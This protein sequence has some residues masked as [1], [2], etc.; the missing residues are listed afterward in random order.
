VPSCAQQHQV[1]WRC[2]TYCGRSH[3]SQ[4]TRSAG[5][6]RVYNS[7][8]SSDG[9]RI[10]G[11]ASAA[12]FHHRNSVVHSAVQRGTGGTHRLPPHAQPNTTHSQHCRAAAASRSM[13]ST[14]VLTVHTY[15]TQRSHTPPLSLTAVT[16]ASS[17]A[18]KNA[19]TQRR[20]P[21]RDSPGAKG[22]WLSRHPGAAWTRGQPQAA[23]M[24]TNG[25]QPHALRHQARWRACRQRLL[26]P[27]RPHNSTT[28]RGELCRAHA[29]SHTRP[30]LAHSRCAC[31]RTHARTRP[32]APGSMCAPT[33]AGSTLARLCM[34][35]DDHTM[36]Q[37]E[38][39]AASAARAA[40]LDV[41]TRPTQARQWAVVWRRCARVMQHTGTH[42]QATPAAC[43]HSSGLR[44]LLYNN[45]TRMAGAAGAARDEPTMCRVARGRTL[46]RAHAGC[47]RLRACG[48]TTAAP[49]HATCH[50][51]TTEQHGVHALAIITCRATLVDPASHPQPTT[52][53][54]LWSRTR[55]KTARDP[56]LQC[57]QIQH[58]QQSA[59][60]AAQCGATRGGARCA[61]RHSCRRRPCAH[62]HCNT[63]RRCSA[64]I[65]TPCCCCQSL[66]QGRPPTDN[67]VLRHTR[68]AGALQRL[69]PC[70]IHANTWTRKQHCCD[71][72]R[73]RARA[74]RPHP[75]TSSVHQ[76]THATRTRP[77]S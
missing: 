5:N 8:S 12:H 54:A 71:A 32:P 36:I 14:A 63:P 60:E 42:A 23:S 43:K 6:S 3:E 21:V 68:R 33:T 9:T 31:A 17:G 47:A 4:C 51:A 70:A 56:P 50:D 64:H 69:A 16:R 57:N 76:Q 72:P 61:W 7:G 59:G 29:L 30:A 18:N 22:T 41:R 65:N 20:A 52:H 15:T 55:T 46:R 24:H 66:Q 73:A 40:P 10:I 77:H 11:R 39:Q 27:T 1:E 58:G 67:Q 74:R 19:C 26:P 28:R 49:V 34:P 62:T 35:T 13:A 45:N 2:G 38:L 37:S 44:L 53:R 48:G 75:R 25:G